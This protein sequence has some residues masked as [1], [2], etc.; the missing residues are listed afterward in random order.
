MNA[1]PVQN[2]GNSED[3]ARAYVRA[4]DLE[5]RALKPG[6]VHVHAPGHGMDVEDF[7][8]SAR[9]SAP[10]LVATGQSLGWRVHQAVAATRAACGCNT[11]LGI[12]LLA[13]PLLMAAVNAHA[14]GLRAAVDQVLRDADVADSDW[15]N[16]AIRLAAPAGL[17]EAPRHDVHEP[18]TAPL[19]T[20]MAQASQRDSIAR[21]YRYSYAD[22]FEFAVP[23]W[24]Q[25]RARWR[26]DE[27]ATTGLYL[28]LLGRL[29]DSHVARKQG[30]QQARDLA[31]NAARWETLLLQA[32]SPEEAF[33]ALLAADRTLKASAINPGTTADL[34][35]AALLI[36]F[37]EELLSTSRRGTALDAAV[38]MK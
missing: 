24:R 21:Q 14:R 34:T 20:V 25:L 9:A 32:S 15:V 5:L 33:P 37:I 22:L 27:W 18:A 19:R 2:Q 36:V 31:A 8:R 17:G 4:C 13:A 11:N 30:L 7:R 16:G 29:D 38:S 28:G 12:V 26:S 10:S 23:R 35:V 6:N 1:A 3:L